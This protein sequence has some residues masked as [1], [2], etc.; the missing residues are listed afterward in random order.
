M[1]MAGELENFGEYR[2]TDIRFHIGIAEAAHSPRLVSAMTDVQAQMSDL[3]ALIAHP[4]EVLVRSNEQ[5][6]RLLKALRKG[7]GPKAAQ[8]MREHS[9]GTEHILAGLLPAPLGLDRAP[10]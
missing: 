4:P 9:E 6:G 7:D 1:K 3:I 5:H 2:R 8:L 10:V